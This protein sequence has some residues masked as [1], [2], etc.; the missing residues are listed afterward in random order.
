MH[1]QQT[2]PGTYVYGPFDLV[3]QI[4]VGSEGTELVSVPYATMV[5]ATASVIVTDNVGQSVSA[6]A[7]PGAVVPN[8]TY[9]NIGA[10][11]CILG[12]SKGFVDILK[13]QFI[14]SNWGGGMV[15]NLRREHVYEHI[16]FRARVFYGGKPA[17]PLNMV[18]VNQANSPL[19]VL[20]QVIIAAR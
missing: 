4:S 12:E 10:E 8:I 16:S 13:R 15:F 3:T 2:K 9:A 19:E 1:S 20:A 18:F 7:Q 5:N 17:Q 14:R 6:L 11:I